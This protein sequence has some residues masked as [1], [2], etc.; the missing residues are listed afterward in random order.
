MKQMFL[1]SIKKRPVV[2]IVGHPIFLEEGM[3][4]HDGFDALLT[5]GRDD[6]RLILR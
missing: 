2:L 5:H 3:N 1:V 4:H 6:E